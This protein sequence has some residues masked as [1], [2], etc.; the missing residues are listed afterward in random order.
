MLKP[1]RQMRNTITNLSIGQVQNL[2]PYTKREKRLSRFNLAAAK[3]VFWVIIFLMIIVEVDG[4][5]TA[6]GTGSFSWSGTSEGT[7]TSWDLNSPLTGYAPVNCGGTF[8]VDVAYSDPQGIRLTSD[9]GTSDHGGVYGPGFLTLANDALNAGDYTTLTY[10]FSELIPLS[11]W[12]VDDIDGNAGFQDKVVFLAFDENNNPVNVTLAKVSPNS[13][14]VSVSG[15]TATA[16]ANE[17]TVGPDDADGQVYASTNQPIKKLVMQYTAGPDINIPNGQYIR[18]PGFAVS[19]CCLDSDQDGVGDL[20]DIDDDNDGITDTQEA[21]GTDPLEIQTS[22]I[23]ISINLDDFPGE[24]TWTVNGPAGVVGSGGPYG[25]PNVTVAA[26]MEVTENGPYEFI[27]TDSY[28][29]G[30]SG[31]TYTVSGDDFSTITNPFHDQGLAGR[32]ASLHENFAVSSANNSTYSCLLNDPSADSDFDGVLNYQ[33]EDFCI[34]NAHGV[35]DRLDTDGDGLID[36]LD[37]DSDNDGCFDAEEAGH[38]E[39]METNHSIVLNSTE[40]GTNGL[41]AAVED[42][43]LVTSGLNYSLN[44][45][46]RGTLD[47]QNDAV[48]EA[49]SSAGPDGDGDGIVDSLDLDDDN[50]GILDDDEYVCQHAQIE[51][52]HN[53][54]N[55]QSQAATYTPNS[56]G[57]FTSAASAVFGD[58]LD[59]NSDNY[60]YT[61]L[62]RNAEAATYADAK[63]NSDYV[64]LSF[65]PSEAV[66]LEAIN[67]GFWT[68]GSGDPEF[69][70]GNFKIAIEYSDEG[71]FGNPTLLFQDIQV[72]DMIAGGYVFLPNGLSEEHIILEEGTSYAFRFYLYDE[73][74]SDWQNRVRFDD[75]QFPVTPLSTCD[76][77]GDGLADYMD[78]DSDGDGCPDALEG[79]GSFSY[80]DIESDTL[81]GGVDENGIPLVATTDGQG[82]G[83]ARDSSQL[84]L[85]CITLAE[86]DINQTPFET[87]VSGNMLTNDSDPT[88]DNQLIQL[89]TSLDAGGVSVPMQIDGRIAKAYDKNGVLA[90]TISVYL[91]GSYE[92]IPSINYNGTVPLAYAVEDEHGAT[93]VAT[94]S[95]KVIPI[96]DPASNQPPIANDDTNATEMDTDVA[97]NIIT[98]NDHDL[99]NDVLTITMALADTNGEGLMDDALALG[100]SAVVYGINSMDDPVVAGAITLQTDGNYSFDPIAEFSGKVSLEYTITDGNG[101]Q[102]QATLTILVLPDVGNQSFANDEVRTGKVDDTQTGNI[103]TNDHDPEE[104]L[105][106]VTAAT[107]NNGVTLV[108]DGSTENELRSNGTVV[109]DSEG[110]FTYKPGSGFIGTELIVYVVCDDARPESACDTATLYLT[111]LPFNSLV[112]TDDFNNTPFETPLTANV[113]TNDFD[114]QD[115]ELT[116]SLTS[117]NGGMHLITGYVIMETDGSYTYN[118]GSNFSGPTQFE[119]QVCD[120]GQPALCDT[121][122][123]YLKVFPAISAETIQLVANPDAHTMETGQTGTGNVM[124]NDLDPDDLDPAVTTTIDNAEVEGTDLNGNIVFPA[125]TM[126]LT[127]D[128]SYT[129]TPEAD[130]TGMVIQPYAICNA[131]APAV[132]DITELMINVIPDIENTTFANDDAVI[133]DAGIVVA[134]NVSAN[135]NDSEM[136]EQSITEFLMDTDGDGTG[137]VSGTIGR[138]SVVS[139]FDDEGDFVADAGQFTLNIDGSFSFVPKTGFMGNLN[140]PYTTCDDAVDDIACADAT[141][142]ISVLDVQRDYGDG[143]SVYP[144]CWHRAVTDADGDNEL[145]GATDVWLGMKTSV[146]SGS[147]DHNIGDQFDDAISFGSGP[148]QFPIFAEAGQSYNVNITVNSSQVDLVYFGMWIDWN[149]DGVYDDFYTGSQQ[150]A[151]PAIATTTITAPAS[152][153]GTV[154]VRLR[155]DDNPFVQDDFEGGKTNGEVEDFQA[156]VVLPVELTQFNGRPNGCLVDLQWHTESEEN[157]SHFELERSDNGRDF[158][159]IA[160]VEG[161]GG[162]GIPYSYNY[163][164]KNAGVQNYYRL[165][166]IDLDGTFDLSKVISVKTDC[167]NMEAFTLYPNPGTVGDGLLNLRFNSTSGKAHIQIADM[168][169]RVVRRL[170]IETEVNQE[171]TLQMDVADLIEGSYYL[172]LID[173]SIEY[174]KTF[175]LMNK[176]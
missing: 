51:W 39:D 87:V 25:T 173:G 144:S 66:R 113:S 67:L 155:A 135:D 5:C 143:P 76:T 22:T 148:G 172:Q 131:E 26:S 124:V 82:L 126:N 23:N 34:L 166:M 125:G 104:G 138:P 111:T 107:D 70:I 127:S 142:V 81:T 61:Y 36:M 154:N 132:C 10:T 33:D 91:D 73:Q 80:T 15:N 60:A 137:D 146:E 40:V 48:A 38:D 136:D 122:I 120:D 117:I 99:E 151:S 112:S 141:L 86:N 52:T 114:A 140:I 103:I 74:N 158:E 165:K 62:L 90:G 44:E 149:E 108:I 164:D 156:L 45:T 162:A 161:T 21:C 3:V 65:V 106:T 83:T 123:V 109:L 85:G 121:S 28:G 37:L 41:D 64:E 68:N 168:Y 145:D 170:V 49:C 54:D 72:G 96:N 139:G 75:V 101:G 78:T 47:F 159:K 102:D 118:P 115:D 35:C 46:T 1:L 19:A 9:D 11:N 175:I 84:G 57:Y 14:E 7:M 116:F 95:I 17:P 20:L 29:D 153:T 55:G 128:G 88:K 133:T 97:G 150:T 100:T 32:P 12:R 50:D 167:E 59:E 27:I 58:G 130:F 79:T 4:Q 163:L 105:Q 94:L 69:N 171:N 42:N 98:P 152:T 134:G 176:D 93:D 53:G 92:F 24:T 174:S 77:D 56:E 71:G 160:D 18:M 6:V 30:L 16:N 8:Q 129:F 119:Y 2:K 13:S 147:I 89:A 110:D 43:D 157:F 63:V 31:N 169:G